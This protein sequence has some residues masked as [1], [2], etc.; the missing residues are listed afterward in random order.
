MPR[1]KTEDQTLAS[2]EEEGSEK[3]ETEV[4]TSVLTS[5]K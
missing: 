3:S 1:K 4:T 5:L 2:G